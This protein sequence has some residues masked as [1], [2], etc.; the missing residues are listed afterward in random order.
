MYISRTAAFATLSGLLLLPAAAP[1]QTVGIGPRMS[2]VRADTAVDS[3][4]DATPGAND[5]YT[6]GALRLKLSPRAALELAADWRSTTSEDATVRVRDYPVQ[7]SLLLYPW[8]TTISPYLVGGVGWYS[9]RLEAIADGEVLSE[10]TDRRFGYHGGF[11]GEISLGRRATMFVDYRYR[12]IQFGEDADP[13]AGEQGAGAFGIPGVGS[14]IDV[15]KMSHEGAMW[16]A[17]VVVNF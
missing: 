10:H 7:G 17:G 3:G 4:P 15:F 16:T 1:A 2:F 11:G 9:Q 13:V 6:G 8:R 12:F 5:R 14:L